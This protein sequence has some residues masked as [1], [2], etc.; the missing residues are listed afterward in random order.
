MLLECFECKWLCNVGVLSVAQ[1]SGV[2]G[3]ATGTVL[4]SMISD[5]AIQAGKRLRWPIGITTAIAVAI[6][7]RKENER[8]VDSDTMERP[9]VM[10]ALIVG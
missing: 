8:Q 5:A 10:I 1:V 3:R 4:D 6:E 7:Q 9:P 2:L